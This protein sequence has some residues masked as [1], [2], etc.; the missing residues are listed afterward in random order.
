MTKAAMAGALIHNTIPS[1]SRLHYGWFDKLIRFY[2]DFKVDQAEFMPYWRNMEY[3]KVLKGKDIYVSFYRSRDR[4]EIL[5]IIAHVSKD[6]L[7]QEVEIE[8][9]SAK[10][11]FKRLTS[12]HEL[13]TGPDPKYQELFKLV[14]LTRHYSPKGRGRIPIVPGDFGVKFQGLKDNKIK[15]NL[16]HHSVALVKITGE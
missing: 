11:G 16:Q 5:A 13:L 1:S 8:F 12:A 3:V 2:D 15:L 14:P 6:H 4:K 7:D 9:D 10:L